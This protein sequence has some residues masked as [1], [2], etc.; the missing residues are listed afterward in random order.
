MIQSMHS[1]RALRTTGT[2]PYQGLHRKSHR[3]ATTH[4]TD[5]LGYVMA[6]CTKF[7]RVKVINTD[8]SFVEYHQAQKTPVRDGVGHF[9][10]K[11]SS[12]DSQKIFTFMYAEQG[13]E[14]DN[15]DKEPVRV[16]CKTQLK[17]ELVDKTQMTE[18]CEYDTD[19]ARFFVTYPLI[20]SEVFLSPSCIRLALTHFKSGMGSV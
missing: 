5:S 16:L 10:V 11:V 1:R 4:G 19:V 15:T 9:T 17:T 12:Q 7:K 20:G 18:V 3:L 8:S 2:Y 14:G 6:N 13:P